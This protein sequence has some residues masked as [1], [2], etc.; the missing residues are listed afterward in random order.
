MS[1]VSSPTPP[2]APKIPKT[3]TLHGTVRVDDYFWLRDRENPDVIAYLNAENA[4]TD[5]ETAHLQSLQ[6]TLYAEMLGRIK[7]TDLSVPVF[8]AGYWYYSRTIEGQQ[9]PIYCRRLGSEDA[10][11]E[12]Y[13]DQN[14]RARGHE[15]HAFGD[16]AVS[17]DGRYIAFLEDTVALRQYTLYVKDTATGSLLPDIVTGLIEGLAWANDQQTLFYQKADAANR[18]NAVWRHV[19]GTPVASDVEVYRDDDVLFN[20]G[21]ARSRS[22]AYIQITSASF[23]SAETWVISTDRPSEPARL[24]IARR[25]DIEASAEHAG[26]R[27]FI[28][29]NDGA[30]NFAVM[31]APDGDGPITTMTAWLPHRADAF[32]EGIDAFRD[33]VLVAERT[34][35]LRRLRVVDRA[36]QAWHHVEF[37]EVAYGVFPASNPEFTQTTIRFTYS[38]LVT[39]PSVFDYDVA[40]QTRTLRKQED[41]LGGYDPAQYTVERTTITA[42]DGTAV[43]VSLLYRKSFVRD[44]SAPMLLYAYGSYGITIEPTF[45]SGRFSLVDRGVT[46]AIAHIRGGSEMGRQWYDD[47]KMRQKLNT[48]TDF[49]D[50]AEGLIA[51]KVTS[52]DRLLANGG[53]AGGL[54][55]G[56]IVNMRPDLFHAIVAD[57]PFVDVINTMLD[58]SL[59]LTAQEWEQWGNPQSADDYAYMMR[60]SPYDNVG[61]HAYPRMLVTTGL[62]DSQVAYWE[63][64]KWVAKLRTMKTNA[65][66][67]LLKT[68]M[69]AGHGGASGRYD[70]MKETAFRYAFMLDAVGLSSAE[71]P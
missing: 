12:I 35:G 68:N 47:G 64:A 66:P 4:Y 29:T 53:S 7:Q 6:E 1:D 46:Y 21:V 69:G 50:V 45:N 59:P 19:L 20:V 63:P 16:I 31:E 10:P 2:V 67:L 32:V 43:P 36:T 25:P 5:A 40:A 38:S 55:M 8:R 3:E 52:A 61:A 33:F 11:E 9:Y 58:A 42:R 70:R 41:V 71:T 30:R 23:T 56:A 13:L 34:G 57:V 54:L 48:F 14:E 26:D 15:F 37:P 22:G 51:A 17:P 49:I 62:N 65:A 28:V 60:Y 27:W 24:L 44:G 39:A 18:A